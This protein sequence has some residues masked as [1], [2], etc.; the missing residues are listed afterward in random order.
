MLRFNLSSIMKAR[1]IERPQYF[2]VKSG[3]SGHTAWRFLHGEA[4][5]MKLR[6]VELICTAL[7]CEPNNLLEWRPDKG[8]VY[9]EDFPLKRLEKLDLGGEL[10]EALSKMPL[11]KL[12]E[13]AK[14][15]LGK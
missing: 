10:M 13:V 5:T 9:P 12:E 11:D 8:V 1:G 3:I 6:H 4:G 7:H 2:L 15:I 14:V